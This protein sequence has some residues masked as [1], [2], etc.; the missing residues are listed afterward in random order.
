MWCCPL[1]VILRKACLSTG[2]VHEYCCRCVWWIS[3]ELGTV[4][5]VEEAI[6]SVVCRTTC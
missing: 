5:L 3:C 2:K 6:Q 1:S 4:K